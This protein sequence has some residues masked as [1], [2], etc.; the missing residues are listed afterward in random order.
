MILI[1]SSSSWA[2]SVGTFVLPSDMSAAASSLVNN[3]SGYLP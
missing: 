1:H 3:G 2:I